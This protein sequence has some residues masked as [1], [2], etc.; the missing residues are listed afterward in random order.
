M[1]RGRTLGHE[2]GRVHRRD[3]H[4]GSEARQVLRRVARPDYVGVLHDIP[5]HKVVNKQHLPQLV[6]VFEVTSAVHVTTR[7]RSAGA[8]CG[9]VTM[10][11]P[12]VTPYL[13]CTLTTEWLMPEGK[14]AEDTLSSKPAGCHGLTGTVCACVQSKQFL[15]RAVYLAILAILVD[16]LAPTQLPARMTHKLGRYCQWA[17]VRERRAQGS[18]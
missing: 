1:T 11:S 9:G 15:V 17:R 7:K 4:A 10:W 12:V 16:K 6:C 3:A 2:R 18:P 14:L 8:S 13:D 5:P